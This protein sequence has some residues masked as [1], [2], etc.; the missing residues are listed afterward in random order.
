VGPLCLSYFTMMAHGQSRYLE[1]SMPHAQAA[2]IQGKQGYPDVLVTQ[3]REALNGA[4]QASEET[5][6]QHLDEAISLLRNAIEQ[7]KQ[8]KGDDATQT[9]ERALAHLSQAR[10][11]RPKRRRETADTD[12]KS[13]IIAVPSLHAAKAALS[14]SSDAGCRRP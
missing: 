7:G 1:E 10:H 6:N 13:G 14:P 11:P 4:E 9:V 5:P 3:V 8:G 2:I 12:D